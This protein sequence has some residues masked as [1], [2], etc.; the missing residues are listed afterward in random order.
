MGADTAW[1]LHV[2][3]D[4]FVAAVE[5]LRRPEL[6]G[7][8]GRRRRS[9]RPDRAGR[10]LD[11]VLR[12]AGRSGCTPGCRCGS[13]PA[14]CPTRVF[15]PGGR[16]GVRG[17][18]G[19]R[20]VDAAVAGRRR[21]GA[22]L[23]RGVPRRADRRPGGPGPARAGGRPARDAAALLGGHRRQ[24]GARQDRHRVRQAGGRLP[25]DGRELVRGDG[26]PPDHRAVGR[27]DEGV[28][29]GSPRSA[30]RPCSELADAPADALVAEFGPRMGVWY[31][32]LGQ[33][34]GPTTVDDSPVGAARAQPRDD[35]PAEPH[36][37]RAGARGGPRAGARRRRGHRAGRPARSSASRSRC[38]TRRSSRRA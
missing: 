7:H 37:A 24:Q 3:L 8:A 10:R 6:A 16:P 25:A 1:V 11:R 19:A 36:D 2:D 18:V 33:G 23:G 21:R 26:P 28:D 15:L 17:G 14:S 4:Q 35:V 30:S 32:E 38:A 13:P 12:G 27:G 22:R 5:V 34:L 29:A 20:D 9:R 31:H